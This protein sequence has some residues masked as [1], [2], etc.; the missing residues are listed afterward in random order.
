MSRGLVGWL[1]VAAQAAL[2][3]AL[4]V[5]PGGTAWP[6]PAWLRAV[7]MVMIVAGVGLVIVAGL[8]LGP[9]LTPTPVPTGA[10]ELVTGGLYRYVR[11]PIYSGVLMAV[12]GL[13][14][15]SASWPTVVIALVTIAFFHVKAAWEEAR[16]SETYPGYD[17]YRRR[18]PRFVP[19][20]RTTE[21]STE[22]TG[23]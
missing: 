20:P 12:A 13:T 19:R 1:F 9:A 17:A 22:T 4:I 23:D 15:R 14:L 3:G 18:T 21:R 11:H 6:T 16:L 7:G 8:R 2:L 5:L 10:G